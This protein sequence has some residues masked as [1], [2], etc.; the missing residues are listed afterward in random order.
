MHHLW[1][2]KRGLRTEE[3][4]RQPEEPFQGDKGADNVSSPG[5]SVQASPAGISL[6]EQDRGLP[7]YSP[8]NKV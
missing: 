3:G 4:P 2:Q 8:V 6:E 5:Q 1:L 7:R